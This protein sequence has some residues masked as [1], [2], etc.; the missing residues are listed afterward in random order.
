MKAIISWNEE[1]LELAVDKVISSDG[2]E[3][4]Q[5]FCAYVKERAASLLG[6]SEEEAEAA[7]YDDGNDDV[8]YS[9]HAD[10]MAASIAFGDYTEYLKLATVQ[11][12]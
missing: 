4:K 6:V 5:A 7:M 9:E 10:E 3:A 12:A 2:K 11:T 8:N 1:Y